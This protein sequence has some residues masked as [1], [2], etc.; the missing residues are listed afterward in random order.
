MDELRILGPV[1]LRIWLKV[2]R[3]R[4]PLGRL[5]GQVVEFSQGSHE[6]AGIPSASTGGAI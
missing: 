1:G 2:N 5:R 3:P 4:R 6:A